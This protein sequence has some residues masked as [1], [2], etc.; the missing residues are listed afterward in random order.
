MGLPEKFSL[1]GQNSAEDASKD[2]LGL[3]DNLDAVTDQQEESLLDMIHTAKIDSDKSTRRSVQHYGY[4]FDKGGSN[5][6]PT[7]PMPDYLYITKQKPTKNLYQ[8]NY[9][10]LPT[11]LPFFYQKNT[12]IPS[13]HF[14]PSHPPYFIKK[15][16]R[17]E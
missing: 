17:F 16:K 11:A 4:T 6:M 12:P 7:D 13:P 5:V 10:F 15:A 2:I 3:L 1:L 9:P 14:L 8:K